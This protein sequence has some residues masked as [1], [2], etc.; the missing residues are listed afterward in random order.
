MKSSDDPHSVAEISVHAFRPVVNQS[1]ENVQKFTAFLIFRIFNFRHFFN[2]LT[3][4]IETTR[5]SQ[6]DYVLFYEL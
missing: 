3:Y 2:F 4:I 1:A 5:E 6:N